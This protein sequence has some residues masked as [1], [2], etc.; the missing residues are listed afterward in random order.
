MSIEKIASGDQ[1]LTSLI[2]DIADISEKNISDVD[3]VTASTEEQLASTE[4]IAASCNNLAE[5]SS[6]LKAEASFFNV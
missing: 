3:G 4:E 1:E 6:E 2:N 5:L